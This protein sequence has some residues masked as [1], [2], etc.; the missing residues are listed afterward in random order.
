[1]LLLYIDFVDQID[2]PPSHMPLKTIIGKLLKYQSKEEKQRKTKA[3]N[4]ISSQMYPQLT[5]P[6]HSISGN[7]T[8]LSL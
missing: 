7:L 8:E 3:T 4:K 6:T 2:I 1:M 5:E